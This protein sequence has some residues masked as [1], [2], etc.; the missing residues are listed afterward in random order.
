M[1]KKTTLRLVQEAAGTDKFVV[2]A[3]VLDSMK[4]EYEEWRTEIR[5]TDETETLDLKVIAECYEV[6][7]RTMREQLSR[8]LGR[9]CVIKVGKK[10]VI[11]K[12]KF[13]E[14][15]LLKEGWNDAA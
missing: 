8:V 4:D 10:W 15:L 6:T 9:G 12:R 3:T 1:E 13:L 7:E 11:R 14:F 5:V 2:L